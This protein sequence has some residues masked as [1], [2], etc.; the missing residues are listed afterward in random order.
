[1]VNNST[2][3]LDDV[4][5]ALSDPTR[6]AILERLFHGEMTVSTLAEPFDMSMPA[7]SKHLRVLEN[8]GVV[9]Q[10]KLGRNRYYSVNP[11]AMKQASEWL[12]RWSHFWKSQFANLDRFLRGDDPTT[13]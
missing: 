5:S 4:F 1:M 7:I 9:T 3:N 2:S 10:R 11:V 13:K 8:A 6:R 12:N